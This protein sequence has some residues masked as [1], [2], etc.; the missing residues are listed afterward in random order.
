MSYRPEQNDDHGFF[1]LLFF[2]VIVGLAAL[3]GGLPKLGQ[4]SRP[5]RF[6]E[7]VIRAD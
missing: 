3:L 7:A 6:P 4:R 5:D 2:A 1:A